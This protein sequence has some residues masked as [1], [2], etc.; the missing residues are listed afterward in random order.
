MALTLH[1]SEAFAKH[2]ERIV[3]TKH[4]SYMDAIL[5][6]CTERAIEPETIAPYLGAKIKEQLAIEGRAL[7]LLPQTESLLD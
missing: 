5:T 4:T 2:I 7:H 6:F 1:N 3:S